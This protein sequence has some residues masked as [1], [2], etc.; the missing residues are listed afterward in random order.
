MDATKQT[1]WRELYRKELV[2]LTPIIEKL[3]FTLDEEQPHI[4]GER[5]LMTRNKLVLSGTNA[6]GQKVIIKA[7]DHPDG[8]KEIKREK[9]ARDTLASVSF[10]SDVLTFPRE[11]YFGEIGKHLFLV[12]EYISQEKVFVEH[13]LEEQFFMAIRAFEAQESFHATTFE[14]L[15]KVGSVFPIH[16]SQDYIDSFKEFITGVTK[17]EPD[18]VIEAVMQQAEEFLL[19]HKITLDKYANHLVHT[20]FVPHNFRVHNRK[21]YMLDA[22]AVEFGNKYEGWARFLNYMVIHN[23]DLESLLSD[24]IA[25]NR[26]KEEALS[27][28]LMRVYKVGYLIEYYARSL[29]K[30]EGDLHELTRKRMVFWHRVL[31]S[32]LE[33][34][35]VPRDIIDEY[36]GKRDSLRSEEEKKRQKEFAVA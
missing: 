27:L 12:T 36:K 11:H 21:L 5:F 19:S 17:I 6:H 7:A 13:T 18:S 22:A 8:H 23:P 9:D 26:D 32:L 3:G 14:H 25:N 10:A 33:D 31:E 24:Y 4:S 15:K 35:K 29:P 2:S 16:Y 34:K 1:G 30:T 20:D 28:R